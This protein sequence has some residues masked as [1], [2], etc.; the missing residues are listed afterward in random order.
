MRFLWNLTFGVIFSLWAAAGLA[1]A[2]EGSPHFLDLALGVSHFDYAEDVRA[3]LK[4]TESG[5]LPWVY[6][7]YTYDHG[8][9]SFLILAHAQATVFAATNFDGTNQD[10]SQE[11]QK[12]TDIQLIEG[13]ADVASPGLEWRSGSNL[14]AYLGFGYHYWRR[15]SGIQGDSDREDYTWAILPIGIYAQNKISDDWSVDVDLSMRY[16]F[17]GGMTVMY[18]VNNPTD[19]DV[20]VVLRPRWGYKVSIPVR[21][22]L[23]DTRFLLIEPWLEYSKIGQSNTAPIITTAGQVDNSG[24]YNAL[25]EPS[26][27]CFQYGL[28]GG[29]TLEL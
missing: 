10:G 6:A 28:W 26:S 12:G 2:E 11:I 19:Q 4:S 13:E 22:R 29:V 27:H 8:A 17:L 14:R 7:G 25:Y 1:H 16:Q 15:G 21:H 23:W 3:P 5:F 18:S 20:D 24:K 9:S